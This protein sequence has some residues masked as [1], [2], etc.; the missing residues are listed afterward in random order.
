MAS[1]CDKYFK[2]I[3]SRKV[4]GWSE[5]NS[6]M[7]IVYSEIPFSTNIFDVEN[8]QLVSFESNLIGS[9]IIWSFNK[10]IFLNRT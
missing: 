6:T 8:C 2:K 9:Y 4:P 1:H 5:H 3:Q 7:I 10:K